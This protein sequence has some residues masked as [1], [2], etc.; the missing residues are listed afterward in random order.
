MAVNG[1]EITEGS[2][3]VTHEGV[4][5]VMSQN[6]G[7]NKYCW[8]FTT[9]EGGIRAYSDCGFFNTQEPSVRDLSHQICTK[10]SNSALTLDEITARKE[11]LQRKLEMLVHNEISSFQAE[12]LVSISNVYFDFSTAQML[13]EKYPQRVLT[14]VDIEIR[15]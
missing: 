9:E 6:V 4:A 7:F 13:M 1:V 10:S 11:A 12:N 3:W 8:R 14:A 2:K 5:G 15:I